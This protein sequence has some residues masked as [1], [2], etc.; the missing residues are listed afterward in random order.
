[1]MSSRALSK[2]FADK[3]FN[4]NGEGVR[5]SLELSLER[6]PKLKPCFSK[7]LKGPK[8][9]YNPGHAVRQDKTEKGRKRH[10]KLSC[11]AKV[12]RTQDGR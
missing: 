11:K 8:G 9:W 10:R 2:E 1:M 7:P 12:A 4:V 3:G 6:K 5:C